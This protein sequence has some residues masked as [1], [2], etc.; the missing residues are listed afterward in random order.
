MT[1]SI[2]ST[3]FVLSQATRRAWLLVRSGAA[4]V[5]A[6]EDLRQDLALDYV[7]RAPGFNPARG[8]WESFVIA[9]IIHHGAVLAARMN[10]RRKREVLVADMESAEERGLPGSIVIDPIRS[11]ELRLDVQKVLTGLPVQ[12]R[13]VAH[14]LSQFSVRETCGLT[15]RSRSGIY[16]CIS[17]LRVAFR[18][19]GLS[20]P[21]RRNWNR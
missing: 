17:R 13:E 8:Q 2:D 19:A 15:G 6:W 14:Y 4:P 18:A 16:K 11:V 10:R 7:R 12:L 20:T 9:I 1:S 21:A 5:D 3:A